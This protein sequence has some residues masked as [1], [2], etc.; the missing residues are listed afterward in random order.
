LNFIPEAQFHVNAQ[1]SGLF[2]CPLQLDN[3][4][5]YLP[6]AGFTELHARVEQNQTLQPR[7]KSRAE[8]GVGYLQRNIARRGFFGIGIV[9]YR[10]ASS[11]LGILAG[12]ERR[13][14]PW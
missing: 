10:P 9:S 6:G 5:L 8:N 14:S 13:L 2:N 3:L 7:Q 4:L 12:S 1:R 11:Y